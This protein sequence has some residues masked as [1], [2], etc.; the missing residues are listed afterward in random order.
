MNSCNR[1]MVGGG[2]GLRGSGHGNRGRARKHTHG[3]K[4]KDSRR[5]IAGGDALRLTPQ[6]GM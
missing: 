6:H 3:Y 4:L 2:H 1:L 5:T